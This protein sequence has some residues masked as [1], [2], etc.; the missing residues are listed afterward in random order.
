MQEKLRSLSAYSY[1]TEGDVGNETPNSWG[2]QL[3]FL[4]A[5]LFLGML[6]AGISGGILFA[7]WFNP[8][9]GLMFVIVVVAICMASALG[10]RD[11]LA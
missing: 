3:D 6:M 4:R 11:W 8:L 5:G 1:G 2:M 7:G 9:P 10:I